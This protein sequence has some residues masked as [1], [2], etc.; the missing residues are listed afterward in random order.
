MWII[1]RRV[2]MKE[3]LQVAMNIIPMP[4]PCASSAQLENS[5]IRIGTVIEDDAADG[6]GWASCASYG[7]SAGGTRGRLGHAATR[8]D[9]S[10]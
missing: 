10:A 2:A 5:F 1:F 8:W 4:S 9:T 3:L 7:G 6:A